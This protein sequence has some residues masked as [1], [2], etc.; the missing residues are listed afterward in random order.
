[1]ASRAIR[2]HLPYFSIICVAIT[3]VTLGPLWPSAG[4]AQARFFDPDNVVDWA[5]G[6]YA[7][8][9]ADSKVQN[10]EETWFLTEHADGSRTL[11]A[12][13]SFDDRMK[14]FRNVVL[15]V[16]SSFRPVEAYANFWVDGQWRGSGLFSVSGN[17]LDA[18]INGPNG[19]LT[20]TLKV[21]DQFSFVPHPIST[22]SWPTWY[23]DKRAG[24]RQKVTLY[25]FDGRGA[26]PGGILGHLQAETIEYVGEEDVDT[27]AGTFH[28]DHFV[29]G[30]GDPH[31]FIFGPHRLIAKM[32][33]ALANVEYVLSDY[34]GKK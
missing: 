22:D 15:R 4:Y 24:G 33:W 29:M 10:G 26:G 17:T 13:N 30:D 31:L 25:I 34:T 16:D 20:Q 14:V 28:C 3:T 5:S 19:R 8:I 11:R 1:V 9:T 27:P 7:Y 6:T 12:T 23:Y 21:P 18:V 2:E 32:T